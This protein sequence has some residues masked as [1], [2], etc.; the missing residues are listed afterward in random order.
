[1]RVPR[2]ALDSPCCCRPSTRCRWPDARSLWLLHCRR[3][4]S[5]WMM[6]ARRFIAW[7]AVAPIALGGIFLGY[8]QIRSSRVVVLPSPPGPHQVG[9]RIVTWTEPTVD[10]LARSDSRRRISVWLWYPAQGTRY[11]TSSPYAPA[12]WGRA[13]RPGIGERLLARPVGKMQVAARDNAATAHGRFPL[14]VLTPGMGNNP[15][16]QTVVASG[17]ASLGYVVA[18]PSPTY[19]ADATVLSGSIV[20]RTAAGQRLPGNQSVLSSLWVQDELFTTDR[21]VAANADPASPFYNH[22]QIAR[23]AYAGHSFG[24]ATA[25]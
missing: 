14:V 2:G 25:V 4:L 24:G 22:I 18:V 17:L 8:V 12:A 15:V 1:M 9:R 6:A 3:T 10:P 19:S 21:V 13:M 20:R 23:V 16:Q 11:I 5:I 7:A